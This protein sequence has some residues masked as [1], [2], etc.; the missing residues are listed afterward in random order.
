[1]GDKIDGQAD[2]RASSAFRWCP[3]RTGAVRATKT[4]CGRQ[5]EIGYPVLVKASCRRRRT[6]HEGG[7]RPRKTF[8]TT[9]WSTARTEA[10][11]AF[12]D[13]AP[14]HGEV[15]RQAAP[16]RSPGS[17][18]TVRATPSI[19]ACATARLQRRHQKVWKRLGRPGA[20]T[21][22]E[23]D[24]IGEI[25]ARCHA[26]AEVFAAPARSSSCTKN[27]QFYFIEMNTRL[28]VEHP[29]TEMHHRHRHRLRADPRRLGRH[30]QRSRRIR[31]CSMAMPS[32]CRI[33]AEDPQHLRTL[34]RHDHLLSP[35]RRPWC[36]RRF[37]SLSGLQDP[38][39]TT[40]ALIGKLIVYGRNRV[41]SACM[42][43]RRCDRRI[44]R[45]WHPVHHSAVP[46]S[47]GQ[48]GHC[49]RPV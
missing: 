32:K 17:W 21:P 2:R 29:V 24:K 35:A 14:L 31:C 40:T 4:H 20:S 36:A 39:A 15:S 42:R 7:A 33:N 47:G 5:G 44:R 22:E 8:S 1:M 28:Q 10:K 26:Q 34:A 48:S 12:G 49:Q 45:R 13:D 43:L 19:L 41:E 16:H 37:R 25:V 3:A 23:R 18:V 27:G 9:P 11:A 46:R 6:R 38:A 30:A